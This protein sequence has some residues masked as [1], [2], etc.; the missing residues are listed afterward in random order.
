MLSLPLKPTEPPTK[1]PACG[2]ANSWLLNLRFAGPGHP[3]TQ[4]GKSP[5]DFL[6]ACAEM[7][8]KR[9]SVVTR[10]MQGLGVPQTFWREGEEKEGIVLSASD[11]YFWGGVW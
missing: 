11:P 3:A 5:P 9:I 2:F 10:H 4:R 1:T 6:L 8:N 7:R